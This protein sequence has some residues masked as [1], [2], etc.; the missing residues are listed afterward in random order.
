MSID[1]PSSNPQP[2]SFAD[3]S[4]YEMAAYLW[5]VIMPFTKT[6]FGPTMAVCVSHT[7]ACLQHNRGHP[8]ERHLVQEM[9]T[10]SMEQAKWLRDGLSKDEPSISTYLLDALCYALKDDMTKSFQELFRTGFITAKSAEE[11]ID[12]IRLRDKHERG[13]CDC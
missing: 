5:L 3:V 6:I 4:R 9:A 8:E 11:L 12:L 2:K 7:V 1:S 13:L 10:W